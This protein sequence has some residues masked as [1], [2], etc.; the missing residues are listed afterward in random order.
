M[1]SLHCD[2]MGTPHDDDR[3]LP[4]IMNVTVGEGLDEDHPSCQERCAWKSTGYR[5]FSNEQ[6]SEAPDKSTSTNLQMLMDG[7]EKV[8]S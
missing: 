5:A 3:V 7:S 6:L 8:V 4:K 2:T 1:Q